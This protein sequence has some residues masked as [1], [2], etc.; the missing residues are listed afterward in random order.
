MDFDGAQ[1]ATILEVAKKAGVSK[2]TVSRVLSGSGYVSP[3][4]RE[5][6]D[7][8]IAETGYRPN[9]LARNL[10]TKTTQTIGLVVTNTLYSGNYFS[11]LMSQSAR[12]ME[13]NGRQL[14]LADGKHTAEEEKA[15]IQFLLDLRCDGVIIYPRFLSIAQMDEIISQH[16]QPILVIN[17]R[18]RLNDSY[19]IFS[20]QHATSAA[21]VAHLIQLGHRD[22]AFITG[23]LDSPT[24]LERLSG[25]K[26]ALAEQGI[27]V[28]SALIVEGKWN[29][30]SG[31]AAVD[32][33]LAGGHA[34]SAIVASNDEMAIGAMKR[35]AECQIPVPSA[36]SVIGFDD[37]P[38]A[39][40]TIPS[41]SSMKM[42]VT[43][44]IKETINRLVSMLDG[45]EL[46]KRP[47]F[48]ASL[49]L[50]DSVAAGPYSG[51]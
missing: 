31:M 36:V 2:A 40:Y 45:G 49:I 1:M 14:I 24:G 38:L 12:I 5:L 43:E 7:K 27:A 3:E 9:L 37:I 44:M 30:Q 35:L 39:P 46:S 33:L 32:A 26:A 10:A 6:V 18:L 13:E 42:P 34:F 41:L 23:S 29:A 21:A 8:A 48:P 51:V 25:Y 50:R 20:D 4:K 17:R 16:K 11:E 28:N 15:A 22:I 19:C 47:T